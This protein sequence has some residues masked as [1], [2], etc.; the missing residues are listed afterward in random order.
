MAD[1]EAVGLVEVKYFTIASQLLDAMCKGSNVDFL[2]SE[3]YLGGRL[4]T[5]VIGG[6]ISEVQGALEIAKHVNPE[7]TADYLKGAVL[8]SNPAPEIMNYLAAGKE[9][10]QQISEEENQNE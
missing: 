8:I 2:S 3:N 4:V 10:S 9:D 1:Y 6:S 5:L 7:I